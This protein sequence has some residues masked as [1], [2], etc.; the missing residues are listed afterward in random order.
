[1]QF[2]AIL[3]PIKLDEIN[4]SK[5]K[6]VNIYLDMNLYLKTFIKILRRLRS[7]LYPSPAF[8]KIKVLCYFV[9]N[10]NHLLCEWKLQNR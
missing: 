5:L 2:V 8:I 4:D 6:T 10:I 1:M 7:F 3:P 9:T